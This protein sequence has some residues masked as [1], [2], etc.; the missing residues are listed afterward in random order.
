MFRDLKSELSEARS[1]EFRSLMES[2]ARI[3]IQGL[4]GIERVDLVGDFALPWSVE[5][6]ARMSGASDSCRADLFRIAA[7]MLYQ[8]AYRLDLDCPAKPRW[9]Q[10]HPAGSAEISEMELEC[11]IE[12]RELAVSKI[13]F[14][15]FTQSL[16]NFL[17]K[18][19]LALLSHPNQMALLIPRSEKSYDAGTELLRY[20]GIVQSLYRRAAQD[21]TIG[22]AR[23]GKGDLV[24]LKVA[25]ANFDPKHFSAPD[26]LDIARSAELQLSLGAGL[27]ACPGSSLVRRAFA[28]M[29]CVLLSTNPTLIPDQRITWMGDST[30]R[31]PLTVWVRWSEITAP[32]DGR[33]RQ[34]IVSGCLNDNHMTSK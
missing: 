22:T 29:T 17:A 12:Q 14:L 30:L 10:A 8:K 33:T 23:I 21:V 28:I 34:S 4:K 7:E 6:L 32:S 15:A 20:S 1:E 3:V 11:L 2:E 16:T 19:W 31:W 13:M 27:H 5:V 26:E 9:L 24:E 18:S 25:S